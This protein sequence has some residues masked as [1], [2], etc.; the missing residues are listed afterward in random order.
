MATYTLISSSTVGAGGTSTI[1]F[2]NIPQTYTDLVVLI[3]ARSDRS[4]V[5][6]NLS[7][8]YNSSSSSQSDRRL[9]ADGSGIYSYSDSALY[10]GFATG[11]SAT[12]ATFGST[13]IYITDYTGS[14][15]KS[16]FSDGVAENASTPGAINAGA[17]M[18]SNTA[19]ITSIAISSR[20]S[21]TFQQYSTAYLYG[22]S[23]A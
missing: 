1:T 19:A 5:G 12:A 21:A 7:I 18:W 13:M 8:S 22:V 17:E 9:Y 20:Y 6:D 3:S 14:N 4:Q 23:N 11:S 16:S 15:Y 2:S 10:S